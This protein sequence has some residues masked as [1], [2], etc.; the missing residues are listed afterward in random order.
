[1]QPRQSRALLFVYGSLKRG[2]RAHHL[3][4]GLPWLGEAW[5][6]GACLHDLGPFPMA[7]PGD[8]RIQGEIYE[9][10]EDDLEALDR[11]EGAPR[12]FERRWL[13]LEGGLE[14]WV[15]LGR[16]RQVRHIAPLASG[17]WLGPTGPKPGIGST[18]ETSAAIMDQATVTAPPKAAAITMDGMTPLANPVA[19]PSAP[20]MASRPG[21]GTTSAPLRAA[22]KATVTALAR[23]IP[24]SV[25]IAGGLCP[26][27]GF[28]TLGACQSW[29][30][31]RGRARIEMANSIGAA[32]YLTK[33]KKL[34][35]SDPEAPVSL[36]SESDI[37][38]VCSER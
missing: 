5:L 20:A 10:S 34:Q 19:K 28:D 12:L 3:L 32:N 11:Y 30:N 16:P 4:K 38:R 14:A 27:W 22:V 15:Y 36:Y 23:T 21:P 6:A 17:C 25:V 35:E 18:G 1:M 31:S 7:V 13:I 29:Q 2:Q 24:V 33:M 8:G 9:V 26:A 37:W